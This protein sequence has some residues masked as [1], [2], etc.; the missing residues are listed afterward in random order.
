[1]SNPYA[2]FTNKLDWQLATQVIDRAIAQTVRRHPELEEA[3]QI[4]RLNV[5]YEEIYPLMERY[6]ACGASDTY[7]RDLAFCYF[8]N[9]DES[10]PN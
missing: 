4:T 5:F 1:M 9:C 2:L 10:D 7:S 3:P 6:R 8:Q